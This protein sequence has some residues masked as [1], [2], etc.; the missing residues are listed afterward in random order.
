[1]LFDRMTAGDVLLV[2]GGRRRRVAPSL[3]EILSASSAEALHSMAQ[4]NKAS[5]PSPSKTSAAEAEGEGEEAEENG[6]AEPVVPSSGGKG[7]GKA[8]KK[9][10]KN[11]KGGGGG[12][13]VDPAQTWE[14]ARAQMEAEIEKLKGENSQWKELSNDLWKRLGEGAD[15]DEEGA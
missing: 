2:A 9:R 8:D 12:K 5:A 13:K 3:A 6:T 15:I 7:G 14:E 10:K 4:A 1:M 11:E